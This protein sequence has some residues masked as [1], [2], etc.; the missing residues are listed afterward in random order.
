MDEVKNAL[1]INEDS[2]KNK[3]LNEEPTQSNASSLDDYN[4][5][6][7]VLKIIS[8]IVLVLGIFGAI[9]IGSIVVQKDRALAW[10]YIFGGII[11]VVATWAVF[12]ILVNISSNIRHIKKHLQE[13]I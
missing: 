8:N 7:N 3:V 12:R 9:I 5:A 13:R 11:S 1:G 4:T 2:Q 10:G 6:E